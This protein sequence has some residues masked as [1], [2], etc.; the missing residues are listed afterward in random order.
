[1]IVVSV[2]LPSDALSVP[3]VLPGFH[4]P[5]MCGL[6]SWLL[7]QSSV[8]AP[9]FGCG[10]APLGYCPCPRAQGSLRQ[11]IVQRSYIQVPLHSHHF[12]P[13]I[14]AKDSY[15]LEKIFKY[16]SCKVYIHIYPY[17]GKGTVRHICFLN[18]VILIC[19]FYE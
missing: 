12:I 7:Q 11:V 2:C 19:E 4:L 18:G 10:V 17:S 15:T 1:M 3:T 5:W 14:M 16:L 8:T 6:S 9:Y 13:Y